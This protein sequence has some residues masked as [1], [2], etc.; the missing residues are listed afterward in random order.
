M[1]LLELV[2]SERLTPAAET[3]AL[4]GREKQVPGLRSSS[5]DHWA[6]SPAAA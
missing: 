3:L 5:T 1:A 6:A 2:L 4:M